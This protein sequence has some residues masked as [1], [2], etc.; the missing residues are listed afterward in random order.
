[1]YKNKSIEGKQSLNITY[2][3]KFNSRN[4]L[5]IGIY[6]QRRF[7]QLGDSV[8]QRLDSVF[9]PFPLPSNL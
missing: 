9:I 7:F 5:K 4:L 3:H 8:H 1:M 6:N 2:N